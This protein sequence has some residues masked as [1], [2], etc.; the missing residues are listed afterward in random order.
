MIVV[1]FNI[2]LSPMDTSWRQKLN[3]YKGKLREVKQIDLTSKFRTF[4]SKMKEYNFLAP[5]RTIS[6]IDHIIG[7][8]TSLNRYKKIEI[9]PYI[10]SD[11]HGPRLDFNKKRNKEKSTYSR[12]L[13]KSLD[14]DHLGE[15]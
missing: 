8:K 5:Y 13:N 3:R 11:H 1:D 9:T 6:K 14:N 12:K 4:H 10:L 7:Y 2:P 15:K